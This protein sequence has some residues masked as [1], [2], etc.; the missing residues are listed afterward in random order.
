MEV[1]WA[2]V[3]SIYVQDGGVVVVTVW[4]SVCTEDWSDNY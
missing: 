4:G 1:G 2:A 3:T